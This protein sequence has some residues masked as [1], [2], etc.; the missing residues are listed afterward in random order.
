MA[1]NVLITGGSGLLAVNWALALRDTCSLTLGVHDRVVSLKGVQT[2]KFNL[3]S[4]DDL[5]R[6]FELNQINIVVHAAGLTSVELCEVKPELARYINVQLAL[7]VAR[8]CAKLGLPLIH[9]STDHLFAG[10]KALVH[11]DC[12]VAPLNVY[13]LTKAEAEQRVL[14]AHPMA[15]VVRTN[16]FGWGPSYR[17]SFSDFILEAL[18]LG[19]E[20]TLFEDVLYSPIIIKTLALAAHTLLDKKANGIFHVV[21]NERT[22]KYE[23]GC[24]V[25]KE[26]GLDASLIKPGFLA[27]QARLVSRPHDMSLSNQKTCRLI[28]KKLGSVADYIAILHQQ[29]QTGHAHEIAKL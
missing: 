1:V 23:F 10:T 18:R 21:G 8:A 14:Q 19:K 13:G 25:A 29:E 5:V 3:N 12:P 24:K 22:S 9:I 15:L 20:I 4:V 16:F 28:G 11:E 7:N 26:F 17:R 6:D 2:H 27:D